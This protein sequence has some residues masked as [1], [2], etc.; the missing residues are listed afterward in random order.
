M[1]KSKH[2][3]RPAGLTARPPNADGLKEHNAYYQTF[4]YAVSGR[5]SFVHTGGLK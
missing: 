4:S 1:D 3:A 2:F 5:W